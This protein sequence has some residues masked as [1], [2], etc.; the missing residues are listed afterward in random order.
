MESWWQY[1]NLHSDP[2]STSPLSSNNERELFYKTTDIRQ[3][4]DTEISNFE[5]SLPFI[6]LIVGERGIGK[7][8]VMHY[9]KNEA[10]KSH[11]VKPIY[12]DITSEKVDRDSNISTIIGSSILNTFIQEVLRDFYIHNKKIWKQYEPTFDKIIEEGGFLIGTDNCPSDP[13]KKIHFVHLKSITEWILTILETEKLKP[14]LLIDNID[15]KIEY[16]EEF[17]IDAT[18]QSL[19]EMFSH[20]SGM[21]YISCKQKLIDELKQNNNDAEISYLMDTITLNC[22]K[23]IEAYHLIDHRFKSVAYHDFENP[24]NFEAVHEIVQKQNGI[25]RSIIA[26]VKDT[27]QKAQRKNLKRITKEAYLSR[28]FSTK[29]F[30]HI[31]NKILNDPSAKKGAEY[32][33]K[34]YDFV[35]HNPNEF[36]NAIKYLIKLREEKKLYKNESKFETEFYKKKI[37]YSDRDENRQKIHPSIE[38]L[39]VKIEDENVE[40]LSFY[41]WFVDSKIDEV[42]LIPLEDIYE[43]E[44][45]ELIKWIQDKNVPNITKSK[46]TSH[47]DVETKKEIQ[48]FLNKSIEEYESLVTEDWDEIELENILSTIWQSLFYFCKAYAYYRAGCLKEDFCYNGIKDRKSDWDNIYYFIIHKKE[49]YV[50]SWKFVSKIRQI[51]IGV[52]FKNK[53]CP[54]KEELQNLYDKMHEPIKE[55]S[56]HWKKTQ[57]S[58]VAANLKSKNKLKDLFV[59]YASED[60]ELFVRPLIETLHEENLTIW[61]DEAEIKIGDDT[62]Q[63]ISKGLSESK[64]GLIILS[65]NYMRKDWPLRELNALLAKKKSMILPVWHNVNKEDVDNFS[66]IISGLHSIKTEYCSYE[67][68]A[69]KVKDKILNDEME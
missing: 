40:V 21:I 56:E 64:Y 63:S 3:E 57:C 6:R 19:F 5:K 43:F 67:E 22:L 38:S 50:K 7:T 60:K 33:V 23:P 41:N 48:V 1:F 46:I 24:F 10:Y 36:K 20:K 2:F 14:L 32:V 26:E 44:I 49:F 30:N 62:L 34:I 61:W 29:D 17:L 39:F 35:N 47:Q 25:T 4:I 59:S 66:L 27:L 54:S 13:F 28:D 12:I 37:I 8:T 16:A 15:K 65:P 55:M 51:H 69:K 68:I 9:I 42:E 11:N 52:C 58:S 31:Y 53:D 45:V 18:A